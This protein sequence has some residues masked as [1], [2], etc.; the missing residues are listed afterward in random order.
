MCILCSENMSLET[1][2]AQIKELYDDDNEDVFNEFN[3][4]S[5]AFL[6]YSCTGM[7]GEDNKTKA[8]R[9]LDR[10]VKWIR[11][12]KTEL[13]IPE[14]GIE[15]MFHPKLIELVLEWC[16]TYEF[17]NQDVHIVYNDLNNKINE[18]DKKLKKENLI[19]FV[20]TSNMMVNGIIV[21]VF[22]GL[23][24]SFILK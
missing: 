15:P 4:T 21:G 10:F 20:K 14:T 22:L 12:N 8:I 2:T 7:H 18:I 16:K 11:S 6:F 17:N 23:I 19:Y 24:T 5:V 13:Y 9:I 1:R 3:T